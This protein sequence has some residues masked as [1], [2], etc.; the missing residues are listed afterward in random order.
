L[1]LSEVSVIWPAVVMRPIQVGPPVT[2][3]SVKD[4]VP[5]RRAMRPVTLAPLGIGNS[6]AAPLVVIR[7]IAPAV[8]FGAEPGKLTAIHRLPS[9]PGTIASY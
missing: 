2:H 4:N 6:V 5:S 9:G 8:E 3:R 1:R 7:T